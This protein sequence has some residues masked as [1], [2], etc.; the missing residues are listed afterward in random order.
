MIGI[1][2]IT[3]PTMNIYIGQSKDIEKR[4]KE[5]KYLKCKS[6]PRIYNSLKKYGVDKHKF[7]ILQECN[8]EQLNEL[9]KYY[10]DLFQ[11]FNSKYGLNLIDGGNVRIMSNETKLKISKALTGKPGRKMSDEVNLMLMK[12]RKG[13]KYNLGSKK[14]ELFKKKISELKKGNKYMLGKK[15]TEET[16][17]KISNSRKGII[18]SSKHIENLSKSHF[19]KEEN[20]IKVFQYSKL[21]E[22]INTFDNINI[23]CKDTGI[24]YNSIRRV[25]RNER[26]TIRGFIFKYQN[27]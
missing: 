22:L 3:S 11:T 19:K 9:E 1:Y 24:C 7:E 16:K 15:R 21:N 5:Y 26:K 12:Y 2:K 13:N 20:W 18:F 14:S 27:N 6:Q 4:W 10:V 8:S 25:C 23:A 17:N